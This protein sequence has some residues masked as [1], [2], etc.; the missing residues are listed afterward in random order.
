MDRFGRNE[1]SIP[2]SRSIYNLGSGI[3]F[4]HVRFKRP[5]ISEYS[6]SH[7]SKMLMRHPA[8]GQSAKVALTAVLH[9]VSIWRQSEGGIF[10]GRRGQRS[11]QLSLL[12]PIRKTCA[13]QR[14][15]CGLISADA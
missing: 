5:A 6:A 12:A 15:A 11:V 1:R 10:T 2:L 14:L 7:R 13:R 8:G 9:R 3:Q 4:T